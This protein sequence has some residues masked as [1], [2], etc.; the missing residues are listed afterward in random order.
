MELG[1]MVIKLNIY[2]GCTGVSVCK[3]W[4]RAVGLL[5]VGVLVGLSPPTLNCIC[6]HKHPQNSTKT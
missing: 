6:V 1:V 2:E 4:Y 5:F 3:L